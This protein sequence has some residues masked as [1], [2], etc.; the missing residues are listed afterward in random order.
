M[1]KLRCDCAA[2]FDN[3]P[4]LTQHVQQTGHLK[5]RWCETCRRLFGSKEGLEQHKKTAAKHK[6]DQ[7][8]P[9]KPG[10]DISSS[11]PRTS[12]SNASP[13]KP[14]AATKTPTPASSKPAVATKIP[15]VSEAVKGKKKAP[16]KALKN[17]AKGVTKSS[18]II[19]NPPPVAATPAEPA[20]VV[21]SGPLTK[22]PWASKPESP[23]LI[24]ALKTRCHDPDCLR[25]AGYHTGDFTSRR[26]IKSGF[27]TF[28]PTP[29][30]MNGVARRKA[31]AVDCEMI[32]IAGG[33]DELALI[34]AVDLFS[35]E[36]LIKSLVL[37]TEAVK[38]WRTRYSGITPAMISAARVSGEALDGWPAA[39][40]K[41]FEF[42]DA[43]TILVG[44]SLNNDLKV[45]RIYHPRVVDSCILIAEAVF[46]KG[47]GMQ[48]K[49]GL[50]TL[51]LDILGATIQSS[52]KGHDCLEDTLASRELVLWC[53][54]QPE[55]LEA[56][57]KK[58]L[59]QHE[60]EKQ[61]RLERQRAK[62]EEKAKQK[63][64]Q[65]ELSPALSFDSMWDD[66]L[67]ILDD[68]DLFPPGYDPWSD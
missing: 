34:C 5:G 33:K 44:H 48:R 55:Q 49:W 38:D 54:K 9:I 25:A 13:G 41:L 20:K 52:K 26:S 22:Y 18:Q 46:G 59:I 14:A 32:G 10:P 43:E 23:K 56:W 4:S 12:K 19:Q 47:K 17:A 58:A 45:L 64:K 61:K 11:K 57:A 65:R 3:A 28:L 16:E 29:A 51:S 27:A 15:K 63:Q 50:K 24:A 67:G 21:P 1:V 31:I 42:A 40:A 53:L 62:A 2:A 30:R 39:R 37:P 8:V 66:G 60:I 35:G 68:P 6:T 36:I 7:I